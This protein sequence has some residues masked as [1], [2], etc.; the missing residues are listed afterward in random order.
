MRLAFA[1]LLASSTTI[2]ESL[3]SIRTLIN[4]RPTSKTFYSSI[5]DK[6][7]PADF[8]TRKIETLG[9]I[10]SNE[11]RFARLLASSTTILESLYDI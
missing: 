5:S 8:I 6:N 3:N 7:C 10:F 11:T 2:L 1:R 9:S 4:T